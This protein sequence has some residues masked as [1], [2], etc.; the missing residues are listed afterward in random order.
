MGPL[1]C[2]Y[3]LWRQVEILVLCCTALVQHSHC[4]NE[5]FSKLETGVSAH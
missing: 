5:H 3:S 4:R 2:E 1:S